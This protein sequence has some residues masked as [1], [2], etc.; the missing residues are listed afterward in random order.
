MHFRG[1]QPTSLIE[2][3]GRVSTVLFCGG[4]NFRCPFCYNAELVLAPGRLP[5]VEPDRVLAFL[6]SRRKLYQAVVVTG[7]EP[8][9]Q[10]GL[11]G[12]L[13]AVRGMGLRC[14]LETNGSR[15][16]RLRELLAEGLLDFVGMDVKAPLEPGAYGRAAGLPARE[17]AACVEAVGRSLDLLLAGAVETEFRTTVV[18][19]LHTGED[20]LSIGRRLRGARRYVLQ[21]FQPEKTLEQE[22]APGAGKRPL[23]LR[24]TLQALQSELSRLVQACELRNL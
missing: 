11:P 20:I 24:S 10:E 1:W 13:A 21:R 7:G 19:G 18:G 9:L 2:Y 17:A 6:R 14:G 8:L 22:L 16:E 3:P 15:P 4:C 5:P 23:V 12:F